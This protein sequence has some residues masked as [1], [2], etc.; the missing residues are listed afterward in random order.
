MRKLTF[1]IALGLLVG[2]GGQ[3]FESGAGGAAGAG[4]AGTGQ[5]GSGGASGAAQGGKAGTAGSAGTP[6]G[7]TGGSAGGSSCA[8]A[9]DTECGSG[10][11]CAK[12]VCKD[13]IP[14]RCWDDD[15]CGAGATCQGASICPCNAACAVEDTPGSCKGTNTTDWSSCAKAGECLLAANDCCGVCSTPKATDLDAV[16]YTK[17]QPHFEEVCPSPQGCPACL[18]QSNPAL[19]A[20]CKQ[21]KCAVVDVTTDAISACKVDSD[22]A[23]HVAN[24]CCNCTLQPPSEY[25]AIA[26]SAVQAYELEV[27]GAGKGPCSLECAG[28]FPPGLVAKCAPDGHCK[29][30]T[31]PATAACPSTPP[32]GGPCPMV[33]LE[34]EYGESVAIGC[35][36]R[37][38]CTDGGW[39]TGVASCPA[40]VKPGTDGCPSSPTAGGGA[41]TSEGTVCALSGGASCICTGCAGGPCSSQPKWACA[42]AATAPCPAIAPNFGQPCST[43]G[44]ACTYGTSCTST[45]AKRVCT[46]GVWR[47]Q[48]VACPQ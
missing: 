5:G 10:K 21:G 2:C 45:F 28:Q 44:Q 31:K 8:C 30:T 24:Q 13:K 46:G 17:V 4:Q 34:C 16:N 11:N 15:E 40:P 26:S 29:V 36:T 1:A 14:G 42:K 48:P 32:Q 43:E 41:C 7:G 9:S 3:T 23:L 20:M 18:S 37:T 39:S 22:C 25:V 47:D 27:C 19:S 35:R 38:T 6:G 33:G 12:G